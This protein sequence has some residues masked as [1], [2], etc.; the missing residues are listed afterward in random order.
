MKFRPKFPLPVSYSR[1]EYFLRRDSAVVVLA[2]VFFAG[3]I[4]GGYIV[5]KVMIRQQARAAAEAAR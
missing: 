3:A 1:A 5:G 2:C 4:C